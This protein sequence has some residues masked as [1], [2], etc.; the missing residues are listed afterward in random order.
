MLV[1]LGTFKSELATAMTISQMVLPLNTADTAAL[2]ALLPDEADYGFL[3]IASPSATEV[4]EV[5]RQGGLVIILRGVEG[6]ASVFPKGSC[7][8]H[9]VTSTEA[10]RI[11][12]DDACSVS[13][14]D[15]VEN[16]ASG[17]V[18][19]LDIE[20]TKEAYTVFIRRSVGATHSFGEYRVFGGVLSALSPVPTT[21]V[22]VLGTQLV[23]TN[24]GVM[25]AQYSVALN[26]VFK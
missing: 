2:S 16:V 4:V 5:I 25:T 20:T 6:A 9:M 17:G 23:L 22:A 3:T 11:F 1:N 10:K 21:D 26:R 19:G 8:K 18:M 24:I 15:A 13:G 12:A 7:V 14:C